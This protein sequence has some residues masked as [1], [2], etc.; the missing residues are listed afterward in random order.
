MSS[1]DHHRDAPPPLRSLTDAE[2]YALSEREKLTYLTRML[3]ELDRL[4][5]RWQREHE[6]ESAEQD[7][8]I[9]RH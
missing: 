9:T 3:L 8:D 7:S 6:S 1:M 5:I 2:F 4:Y